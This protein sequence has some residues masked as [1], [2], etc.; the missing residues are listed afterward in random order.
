MVKKESRNQEISAMVSQLVDMLK[1][2]EGK[3]SERNGEKTENQ[4]I[5]V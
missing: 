1:E 5:K 4:V 3:L 2:R